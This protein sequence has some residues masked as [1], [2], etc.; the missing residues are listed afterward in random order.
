MS[1]ETRTLRWDRGEATMQSLGAMLAP[2]VF[3]LPS[4]RVAQP[5]Q[6]AP[7][8]DEPGGDALPGVLRRLRGEWPCVP[9]GVT[10][11]RAPLD[12]PQNMHPDPG[13]EAHGHGSN[14]QWDLAEAED[15]ALVA[16]IAYPE[17][18]P[19]VRLERKVAPI[20]GEARV[21]IELTIVARRACRLPIGLHPTFRLPAETGS[22]RLDPGAH[23]AAWTYPLDISPTSTLFE[24]N[25]RGLG[26]DAVP[27][28][29]GGFRDATRLPFA[30]DSESLVM[31]TKTGG[32]CALENFAEGYR[33]ILE[34]N[35][36]HFPSLMLWMSNRGRQFAPW[37]GRH[38]AL[39]V[40][41]VCAPFDLG[42]GFA[43]AETPLTHA[44]IATG[45]DFDPDTP[46]TTRY[47]IHVE[48]MDRR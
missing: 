14:H 26:L 1:N 10:P 13:E 40:E 36:A 9:F 30:E 48:E 42:T 17:T 8:A 38:L 39:G 2:I 47:S 4:G 12:W 46:F 32:R 16:R 25:R 43:N 31:L 37:N 34:W 44:G 11:I 41:P 19:I 22:A 29:G 20:A 27:A 45:V 24:P 35:P 15:G 6:I 21:E 23:A 5:M 18:S 28:V 33:V 7:W 3:R